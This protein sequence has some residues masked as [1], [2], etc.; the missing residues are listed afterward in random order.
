MLQHSGSKR[1]IEAAWF[2][3]G[4][5]RPIFGTKSVVVSELR[6]SVSVLR[7]CAEERISTFFRDP[8]LSR[9]DVRNILKQLNSIGERLLEDLC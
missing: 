8:D 3:E 9:L 2:T 7:Q 6:S 5:I 4:V 1:E